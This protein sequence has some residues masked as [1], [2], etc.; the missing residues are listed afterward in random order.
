MTSW[1]DWLQDED[2]VYWEP[3]GRGDADGYIW[4]APIAIMSRWQ[5]SYGTGG[6]NLQFNQPATVVSDRVSVWT[7]QQLTIGGYLWKGS[8]NDVP[9]VDPPPSSASKIRTLTTVR[10]IPTHDYLY[11]VFLDA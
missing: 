8:I 11:K 10:S 2:A 1:V 7:S 6:P 3:P 5:F 4:A 9:S